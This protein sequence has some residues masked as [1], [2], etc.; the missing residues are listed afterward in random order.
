M[1]KQRAT[2]AEALRIGRR[3]MAMGWMR[4]VLDEHEFKDA[5]LFYTVVADGCPAEAA[6]PVEDLR[7]AWLALDGGIA[8][9]AHRRGLLVHRRCTT[10]RRIVNRPVRCHEVS[11]QTAAQWAAQLMRLGMLR[12]VFDDPPFRNDRTLYRPG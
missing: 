5:K 2:R 7:R 1:R 10:G 8:L 11:R 4:H 3:L 9:G 12:H 6:P